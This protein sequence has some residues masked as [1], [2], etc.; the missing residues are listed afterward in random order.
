[1]FAL[2]EK[3]D[4]KAK[5]I[6][7]VLSVLRLPMDKSLFQDFEHL[8]VEVDDVEDE[9]LIQHFASTNAFV[10]KAMASDGAV[11]IH[12]Y[13]G[14]RVCVCAVWCASCARCCAMCALGAIAKCCF[15]QC[16]GEVTIGDRAGS[17]PD[18]V[19]ST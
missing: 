12:W 7:H 8:V 13:V 14:E 10:E 9:N 16:D 6:T 3:T 1:M 5:A 18:E 19:A 15:A 4:M 17:L 2:R 11:F